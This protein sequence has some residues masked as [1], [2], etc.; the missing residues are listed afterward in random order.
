MKNASGSKESYN[1]ST[2]GTSD[3][4]CSI[5]S[6]E[7][8]NNKKLETESAAATSV[9]IQADDRVEKGESMVDP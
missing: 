2:N 7:T 8:A 3:S 4:S 9:P 1:S 6:M 5:E